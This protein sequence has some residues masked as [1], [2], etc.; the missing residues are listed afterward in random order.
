[1]LTESE[2]NV[3]ASY[4][5]FGFGYTYYPRMLDEVMSLRDRG[6]LGKCGISTCKGNL[7]I[8]V[9]PPTLCGLKAMK[10]YEV[11]MHEVK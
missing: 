10:K 7:C 3:L 6:L 2:Y 9:T 1:M 11:K 8:Y 4:N 5:G